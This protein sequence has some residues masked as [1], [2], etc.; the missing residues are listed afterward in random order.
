MIL[1]T[2][3]PKVYFSCGN[4]PIF[5]IQKHLLI[6]KKYIKLQRTYFKINIHYYLLFRSELKS[7]QNEIIIQEPKKSYHIKLS[8]VFVYRN[9]INCIN[10]KYE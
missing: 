7:I 8:H 1:S 6:H 10:I 9:F 3:S 2:E 5:T 4:R